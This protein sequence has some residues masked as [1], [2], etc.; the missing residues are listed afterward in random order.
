MKQDIMW[1]IS[2]QK[3][4]WKLSLLCIVGEIFYIALIEIAPIVSMMLIEALIHKAQSHIIYKS[5]IFFTLVWILQPIM[6]YMVI[7]L[8]ISLSE[9]IKESLR[10]NCFESFIF[11][12]TTNFL[13]N[14]SMG[15]MVT[16]ILEDVDEI[17][18]FAQNLILNF[19]KNLLIATI[20]MIIMLSMAPA[21]TIIFIVIFGILFLFILKKSNQL[22]DLQNELQRVIDKMN[23]FLPNII[24]NIITIKVCNAQSL[25]NE[26]FQVTNKE[27]KR[28]TIKLLKILT[29]ISMYASAVAVLVIVIIYAGGSIYILSGKGTVGILVALTMYFQNFVG[30]VNELFDNGIE[31][32]RISPLIKRLNEITNNDNDIKNS[33]IRKSDEGLSTSMLLNGD[34]YNLLVKDVWFK[35]VDSD[36]YILKGVN[37]FAEEDTVIAIIGESGA[38]KTTLLKLLL[39]IYSPERGK[40][41]LCGKNINHIGYHNLWKLVSYIPQEIDL[42]YGLSIKENIKLGKAIDQREIEELC[43]WLKIEKKILNLPLGYDTLYTEEVNFSGGEKQ[44]IVIARELLKGAKIFVFDEPT[45]W[46]DEENEKRFLEIIH[47]LKKGRIIILVSHKKNIIL[48]YADIIYILEDGVLK[49]N[50]PANRNVYRRLQNA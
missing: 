46:L 50:I 23:S 18:N 48:E 32:R 42:I 49:P 44:R 12:S 5:L 33:G 37:L 7:V 36:N 10:N 6:W 38:G 41:T 2:K 9:N 39:G 4:F 22:G 31:L 3:K 27:I 34:R 17:G 8:A 28:K 30:A 35:Y 21:L 13:Q 26:E 11:S 14:N 19:T 20:S 1:L 29:L 47:K 24:R 40:I 43:Q 16:R 25:I 45:S 15:T